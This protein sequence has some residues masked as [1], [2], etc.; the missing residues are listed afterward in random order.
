MAL[1][2]LKLFSRYAIFYSEFGGFTNHLNGGRTDS[3]ESGTPANPKAS[4]IG[5]FA[6][7]GNN[8]STIA[9]T[10]VG[11]RELMSKKEREE[12]LKKYSDSVIN[13]T[14]GNIYIKTDSY[15]L[16]SIFVINLC[17]MFYIL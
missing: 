3:K 11:M 17:R 6:T 10:G 16:R 8:E 12:I 7:S 1:I 15:K 5:C 9:V 13:E 4:V 2:K 14:Q